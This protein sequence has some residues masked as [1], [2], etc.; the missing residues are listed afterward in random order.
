MARGAF[1]Y[2]TESSITSMS[3]DMTPKVGYWCCVPIPTGGSRCY[4]IRHC[5]S[6]VG[7]FQ[8]GTIFKE[9]AINLGDTTK[10]KNLNMLRG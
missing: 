8:G 9:G 1:G 5:G 2:Y 3:S 6:V 7:G 4:Q 10:S